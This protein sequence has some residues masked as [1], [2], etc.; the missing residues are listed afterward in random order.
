MLQ[1]SILFLFVWLTKADNFSKFS[2]SLGFKAF[3]EGKVDYRKKLEL[4]FMV[5]NLGFRFVCFSICLLF[6]SVCASYRCCLDSGLV[7]ETFDW[8]GIS[9]VWGVLLFIFQ[10]LKEGTGVTHLVSPLKSQVW[11]CVSFLMIH[12]DYPKLL[13]FHFKMNVKLRNLVSLKIK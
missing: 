13:S 7:T 12:F 9:L 4:L 2:S 10:K 11:K 6:I 1:G 8:W 3:I 5:D